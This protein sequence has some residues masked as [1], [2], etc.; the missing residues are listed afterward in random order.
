MRLA[1]RP[2]GIA[3]VDATHEAVQ[4]QFVKNPPLDSSKV[5][6]FVQKKGRGARLA[7]PDRLR[8]E[9]KLPAWEERARAIKDILLQLAA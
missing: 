9:A 3:R 8:V 6:A 4:L 1:A 7:G 5:I 2:L